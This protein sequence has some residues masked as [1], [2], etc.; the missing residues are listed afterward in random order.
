MSIAAHRNFKTSVFAWGVAS[1]LIVNC[2]AAVWFLKYKAE[3]HD[4]FAAESLQKSPTRPDVVFAGSS[5][6]LFPLYQLDGSL[7]GNSGDL[8][9]WQ[10]YTRVRFAEEALTRKTGRKIQVNNVSFLGFMISD[11]LFVVRN[12]LAGEKSPQTLVLMVAPRDFFDS[13]FESPASGIAFRKL[14]NWS[15]L[16][17]LCG[18]YLT[19]PNDYI[20]FALAKGVFTYSIRAKVQDKLHDFV[21]LRWQTIM[22]RNSSKVESDEKWERSVREY[23]TRYKNISFAKMQKQFSFLERL[24]KTCHERNIQIVLI[25]AP[26]TSRGLALLPEGLYNSYCERLKQVAESNTCHYFDLS[27]DQRFSDNDFMDIVH[28]N[29]FGAKKMF[30]DILPTLT[31][32][33]RSTPIKTAALVDKIT[34]Q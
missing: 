20:D 7:Y 28:L 29:H 12:Y 26:L 1:F 6:V 25:N 13:L 3:V 23:S 32:S 33:I 22:P 8:Q 11:D 16:S 27:H 19:Q 10:Q 14:A 31:S 34:R 5:T 9:P 15:N 21:A 17:E 30:S 24:L 2:L 18:T 4:D